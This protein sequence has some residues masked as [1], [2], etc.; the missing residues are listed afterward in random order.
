VYKGVRETEICAQLPNLILVVVTQRLN[1][2]A[3]RG[4]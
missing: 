1:N 4:G 3:L 2:P